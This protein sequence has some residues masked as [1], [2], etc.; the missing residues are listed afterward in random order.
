MQKIRCKKC[1]RLLGVS[2]NQKVSLKNFKGE[3][4]I[5]LENKDG[6]KI[7]CICGEITQVCTWDPRGP[8]L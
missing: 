8:G 4:I 2:K 6:N 1:K 3:V 7:K 5:D